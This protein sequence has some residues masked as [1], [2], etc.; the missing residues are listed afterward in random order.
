MD[1]DAWV[2]LVSVGACTIPVFGVVIDVL[3]TKRK[4]S[5]NRRWRELGQQ[6]E[7]LRQ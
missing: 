7:R 4:A 6:L 2:F 5:P 3:L 1:A